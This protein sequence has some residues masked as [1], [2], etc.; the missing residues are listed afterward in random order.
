MND[1]EEVLEES[2]LPSWVQAIAYA[3]SVPSALV[4]SAVTDAAQ[5]IDEAIDDVQEWW[6]E[7]LDDIERKIKCIARHRKAVWGLPDLFTTNDVKGI[8]EF[9]DTVLIEYDPE[10]AMEIKQSE[11]LPKALALI[12]D[13]ASIL[14]F[15]TYLNLIRE[16]IPPN[17]YFYYVGKAAAYIA[18]EIV[19]TLVIGLL[20]GP[21]GAGARIAAVTAKFTMRIK[22]VGQLS[23]AAKAFDT[24]ID[25]VDGLIDILPDYE[26]LANSLALRRKSG[27]RNR[28]V[29]G[30]TGQPS[31]EK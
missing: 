12:N 14:P 11:F 17:F 18:I 10:W 27:L 5:A 21:A 4:R 26:K 2:G 31:Y 29:N 15:F 28:N 24:F 3:A 30:L 6:D 9:V 19:L 13:D 7:E 22:K 1:T 8:E 20:T 25:T 16:A 23:H